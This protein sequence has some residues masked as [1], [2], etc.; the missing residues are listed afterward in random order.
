MK[1]REKEIIS[2]VENPVNEAQIAESRKLSKSLNTH[3][4]GIGVDEYLQRTENFE[5]EDQFVERKKVTISQKYVFHSI[6]RVINKIFTAKGGSNYYDIDNEKKKVELISLLKDIKGVPLRKWIQN[7]GLNKYLVDPNGIFLV[8]HT[9]VDSKKLCYPTYKSIGSIHDYKHNGRT[10]EYVLFKLEGETDGDG[11]VKYRLYDDEKDIYFTVKNDTINI[12]KKFKNPWGKVP[13]VIISDFFHNEYPIYDS[14]FSVGVELSAKRL[15]T[16]SVKNAY[17]H[18]HG[19]P[20][21]WQILSKKCKTCNGTG[22]I[23]SQLCPDCQGTT[24]D[25]SKDVSKIVGIVPPSNSDEP[26][27]V[28]DVAG[29][30]QPDLETWQEFRTELDWLEKMLQYTLLGSYTREKMDRETATSR[31]LDVQPVNDTLNDF[32]DWVESTEKFI[33]DF[34]GK[35]YL[36]NSYNGSSINLGRR[37]MIE[38]PDEVWDKYEKARKSGAPTEKLDDDI[39][40]YYE[41][42]YANDAKTLQ[43]QKKLFTVNDYRHVTIPEAKTNLPQTEYLKR[44]LFDSWVLWLKPDYILK[45]PHEELKQ[46]FEDYVKE[47]ISNDKLIENE[48]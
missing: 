42:K 10:L 7:K 39:M 31:F 14:R 36:G 18:Y 28:P 30:V 12:I 22:Y 38:S 13:G 40:E 1:L 5:S 3:I 24:W 44:V 26:K 41:A 47:R 45:T 16:E 17:E 19:F 29:Y 15:R 4:N 20:L 33:S 43:L 34:M 21:T 9:T 46:A 35:Y 6:V 2:I 27:I 37:Y 11:D 25:L 32:A 48:S 23:N 8:E